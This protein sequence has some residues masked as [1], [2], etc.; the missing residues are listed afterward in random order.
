[1]EI[2]ILEFFEN[3]SVTLLSFQVVVKSFQLFK[4]SILLQSRLLQKKLKII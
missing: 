3:K 4:I 1:M 2:E